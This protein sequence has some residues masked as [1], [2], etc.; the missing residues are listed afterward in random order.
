MGHWIFYHT[1][2][3]GVIFFPIYKTG[4]GKHHCRNFNAMP[5][6]KFPWGLS[7]VEIQWLMKKIIPK[8]LYMIC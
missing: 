3:S 2:I 7:G 1:E 6:T 8:R 4:S 5:S